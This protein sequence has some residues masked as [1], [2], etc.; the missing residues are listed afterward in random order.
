M[1]FFS[2]NFFSLFSFFNSI[3]MVSFKLKNWGGG[4]NIDYFVLLLFI[5]PKFYFSFK[6]KNLVIFFKMS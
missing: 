2:E 3:L 6:I 5:G 1:D 4:G